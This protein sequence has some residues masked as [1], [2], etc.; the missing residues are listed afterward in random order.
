LESNAPIEAFV[1]TREVEGNPFPTLM[2]PIF[3]VLLNSLSTR[4]SA[5]NQNLRGTKVFKVG[6]TTLEVYILGIDPEGNLAGVKTKPV[7]T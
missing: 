1:W 6:I 4:R 3:S 7:E 2:L 5:I